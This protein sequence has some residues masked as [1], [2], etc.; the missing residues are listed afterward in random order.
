[1]YAQVTDYLKRSAVLMTRSL[2]DRHFAQSEVIA[3][4]AL[5]LSSPSPSPSTAL[6]RN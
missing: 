6:T 4:P 3:L 1:M 2:R 5:F